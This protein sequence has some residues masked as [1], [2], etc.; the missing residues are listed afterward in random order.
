MPTTH[1]YLH[2][3]RLNWLK[4]CNWR[5][6]K[7]LEAARERK[8]LELRREKEKEINF[9]QETH[10][11]H[12]TWNIS[13]AHQRLCDI[14][15][16]HQMLCGWQ[17][18]VRLILSLFTGSNSAFLA[19]LKRKTFTHLWFGTI[20]KR[21]WRNFRSFE[22]EIFSRSNA[23][24]LNGKSLKNAASKNIK[25]GKFRLTILWEFL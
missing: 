25:N 16:S 6:K 2:C 23:L 19:W 3:R 7:R 22:T 5:R 14:G 1:L 4:F 11:F 13:R 24:D 15:V 21:K 12:E 17:H 9:N 18:L 10:I 20:E 8:C